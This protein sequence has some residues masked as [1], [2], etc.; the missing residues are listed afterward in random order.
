[1]AKASQLTPAFELSLK[2]TIQEGLATVAKLNGTQPCLTCAT[3]GGKV[4]I[5]SPHE[6]G[7]LAVQQPSVEAQKNIKYLNINRT[8]TALSSGPLNPKSKNDILL[9]GTQTNL[10]AYDVEQN[11][12][13]FYREVP[14]GINSM[15][16]GKVGTIEDQLAIV[17]GNCSI[18]G[19][20]AEG[21]ELFWTVT[22]DNVTALALIDIDEDQQ[23]E[24]LVGSEDYEIRIFQ[25][26]E[27]I[28]ETTETGKLLALSPLFGTRFGY[29]LGNGTIGIYDR[30]TRVW[31]FKSKH[32][33]V[34]VEGHDLDSDGVPELISGWQN[35]KL[36]VRSDRNGEVIFRD[37]F[38]SAVSSILVADY[39]MDGRQEVIACAHSGD[40]RGYLPTDSETK[41]ANSGSDATAAVS[42]ETLKV[43]LQT[44]QDLQFQI[45]KYEENIEKTKKGEEDKA[46]I[47]QSTKVQCH[48]RPNSGKG[49]VEL[50]LRST[51]NTVIK[52]TIITAEFLF[53]SNESCMVYSADP[54][55]TIVATFAPEKDV[56]TELHIQAL[57]GFKM[58]N[59]YHVFELDYKLPK[60]SM[61]VPVKDF[62]KEPESSVRF[63]VNERV[64]RVAM[65]LN[66]SFNVGHKV[67]RQNLL[68]ARFVSLRNGLLLAIHMTPENGGQLTIRVNNMEVAGEII[69]DLCAF[70]TINELESVVDFP[71]EFEDF[72]KV[73]MKVDE[74]NAVRLKLTAEM[75]DSSQLV[76]ALVIKAEDARIL[77]DMK[78]MKKMYSSLYDVNREL[79]GEYIKRANNHNELLSALKEVN[80]MIQKAAR[81]RIGAA[82][83]KV[84]TEC[85]N[86]IKSN[87]IHSLFKIIRLGHL[88]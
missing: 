79:I 64:N 30:A 60:F 73:L 80:A 85:R 82:K 18:Q 13:V 43:L 57:V 65:W 54:T 81:L 16:F 70:L 71:Q 10:L 39:R 88:N 26:E 22:G 1:M 78:L 77:N 59:Y 49:C 68:D 72:K 14:D 25:N 86:S 31:R 58:S 66:N 3:S 17:G 47:S 19:F 67:D 9:V 62:Q 75:A 12:D 38:S 40:V 74:Y 7:D 34:C 87:N 61:Y 84:I 6:R 21:N 53:G 36:E 33:V 8:V 48:L 29:A 11:K 2:N 42:D 41:V 35:G 5:H 52:A 63:R 83:T 24:L 4:F 46:L 56:S 23:N 51:N 45:T 50:V 69:Q 27:V 28:S 55:D 20:D 15:T 37:V 32:S 44:K 76:K